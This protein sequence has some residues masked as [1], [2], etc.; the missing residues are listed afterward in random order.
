[1]DKLVY[2]IKSTMTFALIIK[3]KEKKIKKHGTTGL[4]AIEADFFFFFFFLISYQ[5]RK[6]VKHI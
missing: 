4:S 6:S 2:E 3:G 5:I 1:M